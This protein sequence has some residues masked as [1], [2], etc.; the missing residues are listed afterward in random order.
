[1]RLARGLATRAAGN[2]LWILAYVGTLFV[3]VPTLGILL[4]R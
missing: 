3:L 1:M 2:K 4:F